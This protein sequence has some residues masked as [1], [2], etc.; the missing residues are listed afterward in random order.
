MNQPN[1][2]DTS[3]GEAPAVLLGISFGIRAHSG[4]LL[5]PINR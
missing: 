1:G 5:R 4:A 3:H 2:G